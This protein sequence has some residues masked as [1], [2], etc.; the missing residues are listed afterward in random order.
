MGVGTI[1]GIILCV[2]KFRSIGLAC[3]FGFQLIYLIGDALELV[4]GFG[5]GLVHYV[6]V[7]L[8]ITNCYLLNIMM[9]LI[10]ILFKFIQPNKFREISN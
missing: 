1:L 7:W 8:L 5:Y 2:I 10:L 4:A 3:V 9:I 6:S